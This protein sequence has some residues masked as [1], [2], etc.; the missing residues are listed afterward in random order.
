MRDRLSAAEKLLQDGTEPGRVLRYLEEATKGLVD[1]QAQPREWLMMR[2]TA[3]L[4]GGQYEAALLG[5]DGILRQ[6]SFD[7]EAL[8]LAG[9]TT[10]R[11]GK[12]EPGA[13][14]FRRATCCDP[15]SIDAATWLERASATT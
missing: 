9:V 2:I 8:V 10:F 3:Q 4:Q 11:L 6:S 14:Y 1:Q 12:R 5:A 7:S 13:G 15:S